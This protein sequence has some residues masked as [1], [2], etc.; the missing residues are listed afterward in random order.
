MDLL[1]RLLCRSP[2]TI[3]E[4]RELLLLLDLAGDALCL[5]LVEGLDA[6]EAAAPMTVV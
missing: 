6:L 4:P 2:I 1:L 3:P 5:E